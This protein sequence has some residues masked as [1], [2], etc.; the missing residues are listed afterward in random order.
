M[1]QL[2]DTQAQADLP[3]PFVLMQMV[4]GYWVSQSIYAAAKLKIADFLKDDAKSY[5]E[6]AKATNTHARSLYRLLR[7]LASVGIFAETQTGYFALTPLADYLQSERQDSLNAIAILFGEEEYYSWKDIIYS[8]QTGNSAFEHLYGM[9]IFEYHAQ[10]PERAKLFDQAMTSFSTLENAGVVLDYDFSGIETLVDVGGGNGK[11]ISDIL[12]VN[13]HMEGIL[14][15]QASV[16][17]GAKYLIETAELSDRCKVFVGNFFEFV[18]SDGDAYILKHIIHDWDDESAIAILKTCHSA[19]SENDK[20]LIV[21]QVIPPGN[22]SFPGK[23]LD[24]Q[25]L[26]MCPGGCERT[27]EEYRILLQ[28]SGF[29]LVKVVPTRSPISVIEAVPKL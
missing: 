11:L 14:L 25:M 3:L 2:T 1:S 15:E 24:L 6:L 16:T 21:E 29:E 9:N 22:H 27:E 17:E 4:T 23:L 12:K 7:A 20:L 19:M 28:K 18:P 26:I 10:N 5:E 8:L 13:P